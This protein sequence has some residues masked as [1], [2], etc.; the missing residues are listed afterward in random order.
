MSAYS[1]F[2]P[3]GASTSYQHDSAS[4]AD[5]DFLPPQ[6]E[7]GEELVDSGLSSHGPVEA[8]EPPGMPEW[9]AEGGRESQMKQQQQQSSRQR[10]HGAGVGTEEDRVREAAVEILPMIFANPPSIPAALKS[11]EL[12]Q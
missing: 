5:Y 3:R 6:E 11:S 1:A 7:E 10:P 4:P 12:N 8:R 2:G 9:G